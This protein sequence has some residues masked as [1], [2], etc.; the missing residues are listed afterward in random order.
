MR[1]DAEIALPVRYTLR[2][3]TSRILKD[4]ISLVGKSQQHIC[5]VLRCLYVHLYNVL[6]VLLYNQST[7]FSVLVIKVKRSSFCSSGY[8]ASVMDVL[9]D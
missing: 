7:L 5:I 8:A 1:D 2:R 9:F 4:L 3:S 6:L